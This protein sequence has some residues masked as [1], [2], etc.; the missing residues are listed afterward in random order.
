MHPSRN[1]LT[2][3]KIEL[4]LT[5]RRRNLV[6]D[7]LGANAGFNLAIAVDGVDATYVDSNAGEN[8]RARPPVVVSGVAEHHTDFSRAA[9]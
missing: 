2:V 1:A 3:H 4:R 5:K 7:D 6:L 9:D 8:F